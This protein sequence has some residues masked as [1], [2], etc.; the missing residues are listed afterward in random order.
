[1]DDLDPDRCTSEY[2]QACIDDMQGMGLYWDEGR[3]SVVEFLLILRAKEES[4][5]FDALKTLYELDLV[6]PCNK[7]RKKFGLL[8]LWILAVSI[9]LPRILSPIFRGNPRRFSG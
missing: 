1:M 5:I 6:Y 7:S 4:Y 3:M 8:D 9:S 2:A